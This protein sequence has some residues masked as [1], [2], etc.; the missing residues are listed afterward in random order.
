MYFENIYFGEM[1]SYFIYLQ[2]G[3]KLPQ[4]FL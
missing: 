1:K 2:D 4:A 3:L